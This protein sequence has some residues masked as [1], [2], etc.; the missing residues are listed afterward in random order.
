MNFLTPWSQSEKDELL[1]YIQQ[2]IGHQIAGFQ[3]QLDSL[4]LSIANETKSSAGD[5]FETAREM[6]NQEINGIN[7]QLNLLSNQLR[8]IQ[9]IGHVRNTQI[10]LGSLFATDEKCYLLATGLGKIVYKDTEVMVISVQSPFAKSAIG[11]SVGQQVGIV[12]KT[13][14]VN[15]IL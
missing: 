3:A 8:D 10:V 4:N 2:I 5:K 12:G 14:H 15:W 9:K 1:K 6:L 11:K 13:R 7:V